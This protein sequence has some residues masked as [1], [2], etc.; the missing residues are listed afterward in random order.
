MTLG[1]EN[2]KIGWLDIMNGYEG[3]GEGMAIGGRQD[4]CVSKAAVQEPAK[5][6]RAIVAVD[7][8]VARSV[9]GW[10]G[11]GRIDGLGDA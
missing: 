2:R 9:I 4:G 1:L 7:E 11:G 3:I 8:G 6:T 5:H 10:R